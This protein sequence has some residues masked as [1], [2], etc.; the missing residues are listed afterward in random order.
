MMKFR[1]IAAAVIAGAATL[2]SS[3]AANAGYPV[4]PITITIDDNILVG[5]NTFH[6]TADAGDV[7]CDWTITYDEGRAPGVDAVQTGSGTSISGS[8]KTKV[9]SKKF[10]SPITAE[11]QY[12][13]GEG[14]EITASAVATA[15]ASATITLLP[16]GSGDDGGAL[17]DT[18]GSNLSLILLGGGL[19]LVGGGVTYMARRRQSSH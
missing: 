3:G 9:V 5:G 2:L 6:Y 16:K 11:C 7:E 15:S 19:V 17:P 18:G 10:K 8:Y 4:P 14:D 1:L 13:T 12:E